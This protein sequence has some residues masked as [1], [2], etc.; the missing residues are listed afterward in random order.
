MGDSPPEPQCPMRGSGGASCP[1]LGQDISR[2]D[3]GGGGGGAQPA[4]LGMN[5]WWWDMGMA[6]T[7]A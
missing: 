4:L 3:A 6:A 2:G 5:V 7:M 1:R